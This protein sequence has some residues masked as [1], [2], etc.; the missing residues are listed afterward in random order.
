M[1]NGSSHI[2]KLTFCESRVK[3][4]YFGIDVGT[5]SEFLSVI[6]IENAIRYGPEI[7]PHTL[8][9]D[10]GSH[11]F[12]ISA[13]HQK[14]RI[15]ESTVCDLLVWGQMKEALYCFPCRLFSKQPK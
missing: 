10:L 3:S 8:P 4:T 7:M 12:Y 14:L 9:K 5:S 11:L 1:R 6:E 15:S 13:F 2:D